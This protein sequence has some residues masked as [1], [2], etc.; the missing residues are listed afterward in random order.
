MACR[1]SRCGRILDCSGD[2]LCELCECMIEIES[3]E[4]KSHSEPIQMQ[5]FP[6]QGLT[7]P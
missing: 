6:P 2:D 4:A 3:I 5:L 7:N 1:C